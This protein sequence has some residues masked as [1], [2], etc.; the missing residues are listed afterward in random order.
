[1]KKILIVL[2]ALGLWGT[3]SAQEYSAFPGGVATADTL[4]VSAADT[5][6]AIDM[7]GTVSRPMPGIPGVN[8]RF[9]NIDGSTH[10]SIT[11]ALYVTNIRD[12]GKAGNGWG[13]VKT[14][15]L[16][17]YSLSGTGLAANEDVYLVLDTLRYISARYGRFIMDAVGGSA[18][19]STSYQIKFTGDK[20]ARKEP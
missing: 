19:D 18:G 20:G 5:I 2:I 12:L 6:S 10:D 7:W 14:Y 8:F 4:L 3:A 13:F 17:D 11:A 15:N 9:T 16:S 1:M